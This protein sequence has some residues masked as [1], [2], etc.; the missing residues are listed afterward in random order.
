M[1]V[2]DIIIVVLVSG[3]TAFIAFTI[4]WW[5]YLRRL[6]NCLDQIQ[7]NLKNTQNYLN[8]HQES[9]DKIRSYQ[10][11]LIDSIHEGKDNVDLSK[12]MRALDS[13][14]SPAERERIMRYLRSE[15]FIP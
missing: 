9:L 1:T 4:L 13:V 10:R 3:V 7:K 11:S 15:G 5:I 12:D 8:T 2:M 6:V 14:I